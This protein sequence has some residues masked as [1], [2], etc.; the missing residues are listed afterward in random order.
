MASSEGLPRFIPKT[1]KHNAG[2]A[3][4]TLLVCKGSLRSTSSALREHTRS[5]CVGTRRLGRT[6][7]PTACSLTLIASNR[8][9]TIPREGPCVCGLPAQ[10]L[11]KATPCTRTGRE[12]V[13]A[14][15]ASS[16]DMCHEGRAPQ[17]PLDSKKA[18]EK[19]HA[20]FLEET[21]AS[22]RLRVAV[23]LRP[24]ACLCTTASPCSGAEITP[25]SPAPLATASRQGTVLNWRGVGGGGREFQ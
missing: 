22:R 19:S 11:I 6:N 5:K 2:P 15:V 13:R 9:A 23:I 17:Q 18:H 14:T 24:L 10:G 8:R 7:T 4:K 3:I 21:S 25:P 1:M 20:H 12:P 16:L